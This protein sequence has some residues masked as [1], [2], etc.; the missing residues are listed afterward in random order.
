MRKLT[1]ILIGVVAIVFCGAC[2]RDDATSCIREEH[3]S[4]KR[5]VL[6]YMAASNN[7][8]FYGFD[9]ADIAEMEEGI[10]G[11]RDLTNCNV[12]LYIQKSLAKLSF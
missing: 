8:N 2:T 5:T 9:D 7:L 4:T 6:I 1:C 12:L 10:V 11:V 3:I